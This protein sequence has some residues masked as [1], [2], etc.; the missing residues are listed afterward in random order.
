MQLRPTPSTQAVRVRPGRQVLPD[1]NPR[2]LAAAPRTRVDGE[3]EPYDRLQVSD[4]Q[5]DQHEEVMSGTEG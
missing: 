3:P 5:P 4:E 2:P 1:V